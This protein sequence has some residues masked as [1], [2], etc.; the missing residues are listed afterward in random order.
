M[1]LETRIKASLRNPANRTY[2]AAEADVIAEVINEYKCT[3]WID[4]GCFYGGLSR[5]VLTKV[6]GVTHALLVDPVWEFLDTA[7]GGLITIVPNIETIHG[8]VVQEDGEVTIRIPRSNSISASGVA[9]RCPFEGTDFQVQGY[10]I[11]SVLNIAASRGLDLRCTYLKIDAEFMDLDIVMSLRRDYNGFLP[12]VIEFEVIDINRY[13]ATMKEPLE[14]M[15][16][17]FVELPKTHR[18]YSVIL[19]RRASEAGKVVAFEKF[20]IYDIGEYGNL[21]PR[22]I[23]SKLSWRDPRLKTVS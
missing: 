4:I 16:F 17:E 11:S 2:Q 6:K 19:P 1:N 7:S 13:N 3:S 5:E 12:S 23:L 20:E 14:S 22:N 9:A 8:A 10:S 21:I 18:Y 15:G